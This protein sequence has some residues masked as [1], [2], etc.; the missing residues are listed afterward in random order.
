[1]SLTPDQQQLVEQLQ[2]QLPHII[3]TLS[4]G[5]STDEERALAVWC[6]QSNAAKRYLIDTRWE[7]D[8]AA[9]KLKTTLQWRKEY[10]P[11]RID[12]ASVE[13]E[14]RSGKGFV[15]DKT[16]KGGRP[17]LYILLRN[18]SSTDADRGLK[19]LVFLLEKTCK[20][21]RDGIEKMA[22]IVDAQGVGFFN[23]P[24]LSVARGYL[25]ICNNH[26][27]ERLGTLTV[28]NGN[29]VLTA[30]YSL[31]SPFLDSVTKNKIRV[32]GKG[33]SKVKLHGG[34]ADSEEVTGVLSLVDAENLPIQFGGH[35]DFTYD[36][37]KYWKYIQTV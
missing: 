17:V 34:A 12:P 26:Y 16:D 32:F 14:G 19:F 30:F 20:L 28:V 35:L 25:D 10:K 24:P 6:E 22:V 36:H 18:D 8:A 33:S 21:M 5:A 23:S 4:G 37:E 2:L 31:I 3:T 7:L 1:M 9:A 11:D 13:E 29:M 15:L 27:P